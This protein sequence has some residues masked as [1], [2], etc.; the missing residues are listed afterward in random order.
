MQQKQLSLLSWVICV[1]KMPLEFGDDFCLPSE[2]SAWIWHKGDDPVGFGLIAIF[3]V[4]DVDLPEIHVISLV[5]RNIYMITILLTWVL[6]VLNML[7]WATMCWAPTR[8]LAPLML[9]YW[10]WRGSQWGKE[11][12]ES[13]WRLGDPQLDP[14]LRHQVH[15]L[16]YFYTCT[17]SVPGLFQLPLVSVFLFL[18]VCWCSEMA[19]LPFRWL[20][21]WSLCISPTEFMTRGWNPPAPNDLAECSFWYDHSFIFVVVN[22][23]QRRAA[24]LH[25]SFTVSQSRFKAVSESLLSISPHTLSEQKKVFDLLNKLNTVFAGIS[26]SYVMN[27]WVGDWHMRRYWCVL[28]TYEYITSAKLDFN[29]YKLVISAAFN[30]A[31]AL[32]C[33]CCLALALTSRDPSW[34]KGTLNRNPPFLTFTLLSYWLQSTS[35]LVALSLLSVTLT[36]SMPMGSE[37]LLRHTDAHT[38][39][40]QFSVARL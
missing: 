11:G 7:S 15:V 27:K 1:R 37:N 29:H 40:G 30:A 31:C 2:P 20:F 10:K 8:T 34:S 14:Q 33:H 23:L 3:A 19:V 24:H 16:C 25:T 28:K 32:I 13:T 38:W 4:V 5:H 22:I 21:A 35:P 26:F 17:Q 39:N 9:R 12:K 36:A 18:G 6:V